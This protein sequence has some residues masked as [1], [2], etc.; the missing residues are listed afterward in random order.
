MPAPRRPAPPCLR[1]ACRVALAVGLALSAW[2]AIAEVASTPTPTPKP[3]P[4]PAPAPLL[5]E[6]ETYVL[7]AI[8]GRC[9]VRPGIAVPLVGDAAEWDVRR[10][11]GLEVL[12]QHTVLGVRG[13]P[14]LG[15]CGF[16]GEDELRRLAAFMAGLPLPAEPPPAAAPADPTLADER[17]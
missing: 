9:H 1:G 12:V 4:T 10:R 13:M 11:Q 2:P 6:R 8:C 16:C 14:P 3:A 15:T 7:G 17:P 5:S